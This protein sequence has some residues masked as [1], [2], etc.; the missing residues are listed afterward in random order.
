MKKVLQIIAVIILFIISILIFWAG[1]APKSFSDFFSQYPEISEQINQF[2]NFNNKQIDLSSATSSE[3][4]LG[5]TGQIIIRG[6]VW[7]VEIASND[8]DRTNG[9]SNRQVLYN[10]RGMLFVFEKRQ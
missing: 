2:N 1:L 7:N 9:L 5:Q 6:N 8:N 10:K 3:P 4:V